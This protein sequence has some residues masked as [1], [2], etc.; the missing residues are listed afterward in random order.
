MR[1]SGF[2][3]VAFLALTSA[4]C[5][6]RPTEPITPAEG[7]PAQTLN[8]ALVT[9]IQGDIGP[10]SSYEIL[11]P[12]TWNGRLVLYAHGYVD[13]ADEGDVF[14]PFEREIFP[15]L[16]AMGYAVAYSSYSRKGLAVKDA[17][18]RTK[19]LRGVFATQVAEPARTY[20]VG[21]S[22]GAL[23]AVGLAERFPTHYD[24]VL[25]ACGMV[26]A[27]RR[28]STTSPT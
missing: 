1:Y 8:G 27:R 22:M 12:S 14:N 5:A 10:G 4:A 21:G 3:P 25:A 18:Q 6:D 17:M 26:E 16:P 24:G 9:S 13:P 2:V 15:L 20:L 28:R 11:V 19:Q 7:P 23:V